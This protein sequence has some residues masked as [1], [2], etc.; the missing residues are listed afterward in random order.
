M[1]MDKKIVL[2]FTR[3]NRFDIAFGINLMG[4]KIFFL[5]SL[6]LASFKDTSDQ[7]EQ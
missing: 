5:L 6:I 7:Q 1:K 3:W 4:R 2:N